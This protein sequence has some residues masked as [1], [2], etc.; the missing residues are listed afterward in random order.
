M[1]M[2]CLQIDEAL[3]LTPVAT[4]E[5]AAACQ[6]S[7]VPIWLDLWGAEPGVLEAWLDKLEVSD[8]CR[9]ICLEAGD[10]SGFHP[11]KRE[12]LFAFLTLV[13]KGASEEEENIIFLCRENILLTIHQNS[14]P[15]LERISKARGS[16]AWLADRG[17][18]ALV[19]AM[20]IAF[21]HECERHTQGLRASILA[22]EERMEREPDT[23]E[24]AEI[25]SGRSAVL[26][27]D[28]VVSEQLPCAKA[29]TTTDRSFF[30]F[31]DSRDYINCAIE[32]LLG[33]DKSV[34]RLDKRVDV[35][36]FVCQT[37][38]QDKTNHR[39]AVLTVLSAIFLP[40]SFL[41]GV[42]GM[43]FDQPE[44]RLPF[45]YPVAL[46]FMAL[47]ASSLY[48]YFRKTGWFD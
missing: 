47:I 14:V 34:D 33:I 21:S 27:L 40:I 5:V 45:A 24:A 48:L 9:R 29:L 26:A 25:M 8:L 19:S 1:P 30:R 41:V 28:R 43:N 38:A 44:I 18:A 6:S 42:W 39:L 2:H 7:D 4:E 10:R 35:L 37:N 22:L 15:I 11:L 17:V 32:V 12:I 31:E 3:Q 36:S 23:V 20:L 16:D 13:E 46:G